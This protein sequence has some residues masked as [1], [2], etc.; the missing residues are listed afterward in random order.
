L[1]CGGGLRWKLN[2]HLV[3]RAGVKQ[4]AWKI[5]RGKVGLAPRTMGDAGNHGNVQGSVLF[6]PITHPDFPDWPLTLVV[7]RRKGGNP[8]Y[9]LT[10]EPVESAQDAWKV[11]LA[12]ARRWRVEV[13]FRN[14]KS[15]LAIQSLRVDRWEDR[16]KRLRLVTLAYAFL[17]EMMG[18][19]TKQARD[20]LL[21]CACHRTGT[22]LREV[23]LPF[24]RLRLA[25]SRLWLAYP[26][27]FVRRG[28]LNL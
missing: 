8:W 23:E 6:F 11:V 2:Y 25:L 22:H 17:M 10:N 15:E 27:W 5:P 26:C 13:L 7:G 24:S 12:Y 4:A 9:V 20:W 1:P 28:R 19:A 21:T 3:N 18:K 14:L 16:L